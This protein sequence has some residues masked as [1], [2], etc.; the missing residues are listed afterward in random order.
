MPIKTGMPS[1]FPSRLGQA[2]ASA[3]STPA[4]LRPNSNCTSLKVEFAVEHL[5]RRSV[6][7]FKVGELTSPEPEQSAIRGFELFL[8]QDDLA[9]VVAVVVG[10]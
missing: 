10:G 5:Q 3:K 6:W 2:A 4:Y 8:H 7:P 1:H 9:E